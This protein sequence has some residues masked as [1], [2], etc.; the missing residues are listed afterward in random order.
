M[1]RVDDPRTTMVDLL[2]LLLKLACHA[3]VKN[4]ELHIRVDGDSR[5]TGD[6]LIRFF[7]R[8][9]Q[10]DS[11]HSARMLRVTAPALVEVEKRKPGL[12]PQSFVRGILLKLYG[13]PLNLEEHDKAITVD[14]LEVYANMAN[15]GLGWNC[16]ECAEERRSG[17]IPDHEEHRLMFCI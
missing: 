5:T 3:A 9:R 10:F 6:H 16:R 11:K 14:E 8:Y 7:V 15:D 12:L 1:L 2:D 17:G 4:W 13:E